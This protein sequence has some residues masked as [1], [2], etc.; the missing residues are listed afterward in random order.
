M[1]VATDEIGGA[2]IK[3]NPMQPLMENVP[4]YKNISPLQGFD[5]LH[6]YYFEGLHPSLYY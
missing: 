2:R 5:I 6:S 4:T 1:W 3:Q